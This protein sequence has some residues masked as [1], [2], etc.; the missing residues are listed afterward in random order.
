VFYAQKHRKPAGEGGED[1]EGTPLQR[2]EIRIIS[3]NDFR[4]GQKVSLRRG[5]K[6]TKRGKSS[7]GIFTERK[8]KTAGGEPTLMFPSGGESGAR[9]KP[10][11]R[12]IPIKAPQTGK[13]YTERNK[14]NSL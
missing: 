3:Q 9:E 10:N 8:V 7:V 11:K 1:V 5:D 2:T 6:T 12:I 14:K 4:G 13:G